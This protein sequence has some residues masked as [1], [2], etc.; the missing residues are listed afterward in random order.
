MSSPA[1]AAVWRMGLAFGWIE[2]W[3]W[4]KHRACKVTGFQRKV[5]NLQM[6]SN[7]GLRFVFPEFY[8]IIAV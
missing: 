5:S 2:A 4:I 7:Y 1:L 6:Q 3:G 8:A